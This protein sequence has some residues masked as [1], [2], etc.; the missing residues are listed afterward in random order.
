MYSSPKNLTS[1]RSSA[2]GE[3]SAWLS[4]STELRTSSPEVEKSPENNDETDEAHWVLK[5]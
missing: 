2:R 1:A 3:V 4:L 5:D